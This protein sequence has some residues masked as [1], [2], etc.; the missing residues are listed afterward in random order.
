MN[1]ITETPAVVIDLAPVKRNIAKLREYSQK[2]KIAVRPHTKT[3]KSIAMGQLQIEAGAIGLTVAKAGE[4]EIMANASRDILIAYPAFDAGRCDRVAQLAKT[5]TVHVGL[6]SAFAASG[7]AEAARRA[8]TTVGILVDLDVGMHRTGLQ[9]PKQTLEL[10]QAVSNT[11]GL[12][13]DG[14]MCYPG[15]LKCPVDEQVKD[16]KRIDALL[17]QTIDLWRKSG[18]EAKIVSGGSTPALYQSHHVTA[19]TEVR[20]GTYIYNDVNTL[21]GGFCTID[22]C[23]AKVVCTVISDSVPGKFVIDAGSKT[24]TSDRCGVNPDTAG[25]G[26][27]V[28]YPR[29]RISRLTEEHGEVELNGGEK[30]KLGEQ[31]HVIPNHICPCI[32]LHDRFWLRDERGQ[33]SSM[34]VDARGRVT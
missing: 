30:P 2:H 11:P 4:A 14:I 27:I 17:H 16:L 3:H 28:E 22:E 1:T 20:P 23:A 8:G 13:L 7:I 33:L 25:H 31:V 32:N 9:S 19:F 29:A 24:L 18:L 34:P 15:H 6:D 12:R 21:A 5:H 26:R 10:A